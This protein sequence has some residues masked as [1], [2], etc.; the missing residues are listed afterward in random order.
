MS[1][2]I[3][4][5]NMNEVKNR[6]TETIKS[7]FASFIPDDKWKALVEKQTKVFLNSDLPDIVREE[8]SSIMRERVKKELDSAKYN[9]LYDG[10]VPEI[11]EEIITKH[12]DKLV[13]AMAAK[14]M[15]E[16]LNHIRYNLPNMNI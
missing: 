9:R 13:A 11:V 10:I 15:A 4:T 3:Q 7:Q 12:A 8:L 16:V 1:K 14:P 6:I 5:F 2:D